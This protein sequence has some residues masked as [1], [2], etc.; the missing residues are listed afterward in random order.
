MRS[1]AICIIVGI[2]LNTISL[3][4]QYSVGGT[5]PSFKLRSKSALQPEFIAAPDIKK[6]EAEDVLNE[7][8]GTPLRIAENISTD[9]CIFQTGTWD[10][11]STGERI[12]RLKLHSPGA[13]GLRLIYKDFYLPAGAKLFLYTEDKDFV[14][15]AF[16]DAN[17]NASRLFAT[18]ITPG[19]SCILEY[20]EPSYVVDKPSI[21]ISEVGYVYKAIHVLYPNTGSRLKDASGTCNV[22]VNCSPEGDNWKDVKRSVAYIE[23]HGYLCSGNLLNNTAQDFRNFFSTAHHCVFAAKPS[24]AST[25]VFY[26]N[27][28][29]SE[30]SNTSTL[31]NAAVITGA[32]VR[33]ISPY[34]NGGDGALLELFGPVLDNYNLYWSGWDRTDSIVS[35]G[36]SIHHPNGDFKKIST[37]RAPWYTSTWYSDTIKG[38]DNAHWSVRFEATENGHGVTEGGSSGSGLFGPDELF[39]GSL[40]GGYNDCRLRTGESSYGKLYYNWD[41]YSN[42]DTLRFKP[43]L[44]PLNTGVIRLKGTE[45]NLPSGTQVY[46]TSSSPTVEIDSSVQFKDETSGSNLTRTWQFEGGTPPTS[47]LAEPIVKY[48]QPG[49]YDVT[50]EI[51][52]GQNTIIKKRTDYVYVNPKP[53]WIKQ[54]TAFSRASYGISGICIADTNSVWAWAYDGINP[55]KQVTLYTRT[56]NAGETWKPDSIVIPGVKGCGIGNIFALNKDTAYAT[57]FAPSPPGGGYIVC[58]RNGGTTWEIQSSATFSADKGFPNFVY[59]FNKNEGV[60]GGDPN[61]GY[62]EIYTT[63]NG[64][65]TWT[66]VPSANIPNEFSDEYGTVN[67]YDAVSDTV[68]FGTSRGRVYRSINKGLTWTVTSTGISGQTDVKFRNGNLGYAFTKSDA[69]GNFVLKRTFNGGNTW[70]TVT[71]EPYFLEGDLAYVPGTKKAW[72]NVSSGFPSGTSFSTDDGGTF[73]SIDVGLRFTSVAFINPR[74]G[75]AGTFNDSTSGGIYKWDPHNLMLTSVKEVINDTK[76]ANA[77]KV[78]PNPAEKILNIVS[79]YTS[80]KEV[81]ILLYDMQGVCRRKERTNASFGSFSRSMDISDLKP[82]VYTLIIQGKNSKEVFKII[83]L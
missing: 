18:Q 6:L 16:T 48:T 21:C 83:K 10:T 69:S 66:R 79:A 43:W 19:E 80:S 5:P 68:W 14:I 41:K 8:A 51:N 61:N 57:V 22:N 3:S 59:F 81:N 26:F 13:L 42:V 77:F 28:E 31:N 63:S 44:D 34:Q 27:R 37:V 17:N 40:T 64:G 11:L 24:T 49:A 54:N 20:V 55:D 67:M 72:I 15:G 2:V 53:A 78:F 74:F 50:L 29:R 46:W 70:T 35:G 7:K 12:W 71:L 32:Y 47:T 39:R 73:R 76:I 56:T 33:A 23:M 9:L 82:G 36:V 60:C 75:W 65:N 25:W 38:A 45:K 30:C 62:F 1:L 52:D 58:T 4:A